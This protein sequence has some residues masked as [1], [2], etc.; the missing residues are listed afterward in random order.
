MSV[1]SIKVVKMAVEL[2][3]IPVVVSWITAAITTRSAIKQKHEDLR[4]DIEKM[5]QEYK[6]DVQM[7]KYENHYN[8]LIEIYEDLITKVGDFLGDTN[9]DL[10]Y[11]IAQAAVT[12]V[13]LHSEGNLEMKLL[14]LRSELGEFKGE[15][16]FGEKPVTTVGC[17]MALQELVNELKETL[18]EK[19]LKVPE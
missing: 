18:K 7:K 5:R 16:T 1:E 10:K 4:N 13:Q 11:Q 3:L 17:Q 2:L 9:S 6:H 12:K 14:H 8:H 19:D 15:G